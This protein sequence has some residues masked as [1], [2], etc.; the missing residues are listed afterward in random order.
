MRNQR[1]YHLFDHLEWSSI[2]YLQS[3][4]FTL[5]SDIREPL[6]PTFP[7]STCGS[8]A[9]LRASVLGSR[10]R[11]NSWSDT[12]VH[13]STATPLVITWRLQWCM[14]I[15]CWTAGPKSLQTGTWNITEDHV[16]LNGQ[17]SGQPGLARCL[18]G[19]KLNDYNSVAEFLNRLNRS[20][21][22]KWAQDCCNDNYHHIIILR[23]CC[24]PSPQG[25]VMFFLEMGIKGQG[26]AFGKPDAGSQVFL[27][28]SFEFV[29]SFQDLQC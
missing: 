15:Y 27:K 29:F 28:K 11:R 3:A 14:V 23:H 16:S 5:H 19:V 1:N 18:V 9:L 13:L 6:P 25:K 2:K 7:L 12:C 17:K 8:P 21:T 4:H 10:I 20:W 26:L 24:L 22:S